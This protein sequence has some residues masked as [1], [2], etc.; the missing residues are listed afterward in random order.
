MGPRTLAGLPVV[1]LLGF[2]WPQWPVDAHL[3]EWFGLGSDFMKYAATRTL[4]WVANGELIAAWSLLGVMLLGILPWRRVP[5]GAVGRDARAFLTPLRRRWWR[6]PLVPFAMLRAAVR[7]WPA[8][9]R[10]RA[11]WWW[12]VLWVALPMT[13]LALTWL[14]RGSVWYARIW[15]SHTITE[16]WEPRYL[17]IIV[18]AW[19]LWLAAA[20]RRLPTWPL[21]TLAI[22]AVVAV[23]VASALTNHLLYRQAP[24]GHIADIY[25]RYVKSSGGPEAVALGVPNTRWTGDA[26]IDQVRIALGE[27]PRGGARDSK[28]PW[29]NLRRG[30]GDSGLP[31]AARGF[32]RTNTIQT[33]ILV[34]R[35]GD[36]N[37]GMVG[38][39]AI[40]R[41]LGKGWQ[42]TSTETFG[43][44]YEW[45][46]YFRHIWRVRVWQRQPAASG[47]AAE[48]QAAGAPTGK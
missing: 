32:A 41:A 21:R 20:L 6:L 34:D 13:V 44:Y 43:W 15:G 4:P 36:Q 29:R 39:E 2:L 42:L 35:L 11:P 10:A 18:P 14:P 45:H 8:R 12:V 19:I 16:I 47:A 9:P 28:V 1:H 26:D 25:A 23:S 27:D 33:I 3:S 17:G 31:T 30:L 7:H 38:Q 37:D 22:A 40:E 5:Y 24:W 46:Y 48:T